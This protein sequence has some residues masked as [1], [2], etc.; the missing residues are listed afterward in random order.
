MGCLRFDRDDHNYVKQSYPVFQNG[1]GCVYPCW[2]LLQ[3]CNPIP[4]FSWFEETGNASRVLKDE[5]LFLSLS[6]IVYPKDR[7][8]YLTAVAVE[9]VYVVT[10]LILVLFILVFLH[11]S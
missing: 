1:T 2:R 5:W 6:Q 4:P 8:F 9:I 7:N 3:I 10:C 11:A